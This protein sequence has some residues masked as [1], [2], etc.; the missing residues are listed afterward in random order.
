MREIST[1]PDDAFVSDTVSAR[2]A[3]ALH[4]L[5]DCA[6]SPPLDGEVLPP[7]WHWLAFLPDAA[8][9]DLGDDGHP[10]IGPVLAPAGLP[11]RMYAGGLLKF[12]GTVR[13]GERLERRSTYSE[14]VEKS[15]RSGRLAF[16]QAEHSFSSHGRL[17]V[18]E[19]QDLVYRPPADPSAR[20]VAHAE[21]PD[22]TFWEWSWTLHVDPRLLFRFSALTYNTHRI[23]YD[24]E[25]ARSVEGYRGLVVHGPLQAVA[26]ADLVRRSLPEARLTTFAFKAL[27][28]AFD[29]GDLS[30]RG[31][32][33]DGVIELGAFDSSGVMTMTAHASTAQTEGSTERS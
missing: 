21:E 3:A 33:A 2:S 18:V 30:L 16:V 5:F 15:G 14:P 31:R 7:L 25:Y 20:P 22:S 13:V 27:R 29:D 6:G 11:R 9:R 17:G 1:E 10:V 12:P 24:R 26:L 8:Q 32:R 19:T 28:P 23:H 4:G